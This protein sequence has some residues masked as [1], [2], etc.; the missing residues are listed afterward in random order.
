MRRLLV[1]A[2]LFG[3]LCVPAPAQFSGG[4]VNAP[5]GVLYSRV[6]V[7]FNAG[8]TD[9]TIPI[10][11]PPGF[12]RWKGL[13]SNAGG[14]VISGASGS[15]STATFG[16]FTATGGGGTAIVAAATAITVTTASEG[17]ANNTQSINAANS[18]TISYTVTSIFFRVGTAQGAPATGT[19]TFFYQPVS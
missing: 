4:I 7:D 3:W 14:I 1:L 12:T 2:L 16:V 6:T 10:V 9:T 13:N 8:N 17:T 18:G 5:N 19:V 11:L 15:L